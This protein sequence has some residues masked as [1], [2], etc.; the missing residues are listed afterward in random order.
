MS[1]FNELSQLTIEELNSVEYLPEYAPIILPAII[2]MGN[3]SQKNFEVSIDT[4][5]RVMVESEQ[6]VN[7]TT[8]TYENNTSSLFVTNVDSFNYYG[9]TKYWL[10]K[11]HSAK[12]DQSKFDFANKSARSNLNKVFDADSYKGDGLNK[13]LISDVSTSTLTY[14]T[15]D[16][17][18]QTLVAK[19]N[20]FIIDNSL[21]NSD[22]V[23]MMVSGSIYSDL[24]LICLNGTKLVS[25]ALADANIFV[26]YTPDYMNTTNR[27]DFVDF[28]GLEAIYGKLPQAISTIDI[29]RQPDSINKYAE[30]YI[31]HQSVA[32]YKR[33]SSTVQSYL[34]V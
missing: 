18:F 19:K 30:L 12:F 10:I 2:S 4:L 9:F 7:P 29:V 3:A 31:G 20:K 5:M 17:L 11:E 22:T 28:K 25:Q 15:G 8:N 21:M 13:G 27:V 6:V 34:K 26:I 14:T 16:T 33:R 24:S 1:S 32:I 23:Y